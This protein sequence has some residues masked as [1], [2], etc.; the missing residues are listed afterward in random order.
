MEL[1]LNGCWVNLSPVHPLVVCSMV[2]SFVLVYASVRV[3][4]A[5][6]F[7]RHKILFYGVACASVLLVAGITPKGLHLAYTLFVEEVDSV[8]TYPFTV[9]VVGFPPLLAAVIAVLSL[10]WGRRREAA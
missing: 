1:F 7:R 9:L 8:G 10:K 6:L 2:L 4:G 5:A 3:T